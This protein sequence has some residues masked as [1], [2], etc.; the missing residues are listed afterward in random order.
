MNE[1][2]EVYLY[3]TRLNTTMDLV[4][5]GG[6]YSLFVAPMIRCMLRELSEYIKY[7]FGSAQV[8][9]GITPSI[10]ALLGPTSEEPSLLA[11]IGRRRFL[12]LLLAAS[13]PSIYTNRAFE[14]HHSAEILKERIDRQHVNP[15]LHGRYR[16]VIIVLEYALALMALANVATISWN[17]GIQAIVVVIPILFVVL[18]WSLSVFIVMHIILGTLTLSSIIFVK[19]KDALAIMARYIASVVVC[20]MILLYE[21]AVIRNDRP[22]T[23]EV[24]GS[25]YD[26]TQE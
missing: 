24:E 19:S 17:L 4:S 12:A 23:L 5:G 9:P 8:I 16:R 20:R 7:T 2:Q 11:L 25:R 14:Y 18:A 21:L 13:S 3:G 15:S 1:I 22:C 6:T 26:Q 10:L